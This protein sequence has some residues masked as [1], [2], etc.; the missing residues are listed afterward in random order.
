MT[1]PSDDFNVAGSAQSYGMP[2]VVEQTAGGERGYD[3]MSRLMKDNVVMLHG[4][5]NAGMAGIIVAQLLYLGSQLAGKEG[6]TITMYVDSPGGSV[7]AGMSIYDT[8]NFV[9][10]KYGVPIRT[11]GMGMNMSM[12]SFLLCAGTPGYRSILP[13]ADHMVHQPSAGSQG[14]VSDM[15]ITQDCVE[16]VKQRLALLYAA[17]SKM[18]Y[19]QVRQLSDRDSFLRAEEC[20]TLGLVDRIMY[21]DEIM[22]RALEKT[23]PNQPAVNYPPGMKEHLERISKVQREANKIHA[24][25]RP[26]AD[27]DPGPYKALIASMDQKPA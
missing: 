5:V 20:V 7:N 6:K 27:V 16:E 3:L 1:H 26:G 25:T 8:M 11:I 14:K 12:G 23:D 4:P 9:Q 21:P 15:G 2:M 10:A 18:T 19:E 17:H 22:Q 24:K 13:N